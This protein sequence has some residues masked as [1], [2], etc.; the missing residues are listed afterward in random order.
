M[1]AAYFYPFP[2]I[3]LGVVFLIAIPSQ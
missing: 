3:F 1:E 2:V